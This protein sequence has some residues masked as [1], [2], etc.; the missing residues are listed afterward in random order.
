MDFLM[1][2]EAGADWAQVRGFAPIGM[3]ES[4]HYSIIPCGCQKKTATKIT[5]IPI[6]CRI[7]ETSS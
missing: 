2:Q 4:F 7:S 6:G 1:R 3:M 5:I